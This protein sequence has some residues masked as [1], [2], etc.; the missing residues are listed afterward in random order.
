MNSM[1]RRHGFDD[2]IIMNPKRH[3]DAGGAQESRFFSNYAGFSMAFASV[4][5]ASLK[6]RRGS[7]V[8]DPWNGSGVTTRTAARLGYR[9]I[10]HDLNPAMIL[11][12]SADLLSPLQVGSLIS[13]GADIVAHSRHRP[14]TLAADP[15]ID[16]IDQP[17]TAIVRGLEAAINARISHRH[18]YANLGIAP[19]VNR[20]DPSTAFLYVALFN[21]TKQLT[22]KFIASNPTWIKKPTKRRSRA[23]ASAERVFD[24]FSGEVNRLATS[25]AVHGT[26]NNGPSSAGSIVLANSQNMPT[27]TA[28]VDLVVTSPPYC[29]RIDYAVATAIQLAVLRVGD[30]DFMR[31]RRSLMGTSTVAPGTSGQP[32]NRWGVTCNSFLRK[33]YA[34]DSK[35]SQSYYFKNHTQYFDALFNSLG[36]IARVLRPS[37]RCVIVVQDSYYKEVHNDVPQVVVEMAHHHGMSLRRQE[38]FV[39]GRSMAGVNRNARKYVRSRQTK[40]CVLCFSRD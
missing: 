25:L 1:P 22:A 4:L 35:A 30:Q 24:L 12:A 38:S 36:E 40:E 28:S 7:C 23:R 37:G 21:V 18:A 33:L 32:Q 29:T 27:A 16:W 5:L 13:I 14:L 8:L 26:A 9:A 15:L 31:L 39:T 6:L 19:H 10:G 3:A 20:V 11:V 17:T 2:A 34:H